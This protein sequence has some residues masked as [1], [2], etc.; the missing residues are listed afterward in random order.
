MKKTS[1]LPVIKHLK[2]H[3]FS[4]VFKE[5]NRQKESSFSRKRKL[6]FTSLVVSQIKGVTK[7]LSVEIA[8]IFEWESPKDLDKD[9]TKQAYSEY[10]KDLKYEA[11]NELNRVAL[12]KV[13]QEYDVKCYKGKYVIGMIDGTN[14]ELPNEKALTAHFGQAT[15]GAKSFKDYMTMACGS[16]CYDVLNNLSWDMII[17]PYASSERELATQHLENLMASPV[18]DM[19]SLS[20]S[21]RTH[22]R[23]IIML[24]DRGYPSFKL[25][26]ELLG[27]MIGFVCRSPKDFC[28]EM[29]TFV[30][31]D[32]MDSLVE[33]KLNTK[34][35]HYGSLYPLF[36]AGQVVPDSI[37]LRFIKIPLSTGETEYLITDR[38][39]NKEFLYSDF[40]TLYSLRWG[41][42][43]QYDYLKN[44]LEIENLS[45]KLV[46]SV[47][48]D[49]YSRQLSAN[50]CH[51]M[52]AEAQ[53]ILDEKKGDNSVKQDE[54]DPVI[55]PV[56]V[57]V[58]EV[59]K[60]KKNNS[61]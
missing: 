5:R 34:D 22:N 29:D 59:E 24:F 60:K 16:V 18:P 50:I 33:I 30:A 2:E 32:S 54:I 51:L 53:V 3:L 38:C 58:K 49:A 45:G 48:Q 13:Y 6:S 31:S 37:T 57:E 7:S 39:D 46:N 42:E 44:T 15:G 56:L 25:F 28:T 17:A 9:Y 14:L 12:N 11:Y 41:G 20:S 23:E 47:L 27:Q 61:L 35:R 19:A 10:R 52:I 21:L 40:D 36:K 1:Y 55:D 26:I 4:T 8:S 43:T